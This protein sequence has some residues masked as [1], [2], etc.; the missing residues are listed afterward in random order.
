ML[1][2]N[3]GKLINLGMNAQ[4]G[5]NT[6]EA[7]SLWFCF[8]ICHLA[9]IDT[10]FGMFNVIHFIHIW[11]S[12]CKGSSIVA[13]GKW[14]YAGGIPMELAQPLFV[15]WIPNI[16]KSIGTS[17]KWIFKSVVNSNGENGKSEKIQYRKKEKTK[18]SGIT[19]SVKTTG[20]YRLASFSKEHEYFPKS[21]FKQLTHCIKSFKDSAYCKKY[22]L[23]A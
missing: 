14:R 15:K 9:N 23:N 22:Y 7:Y 13:E 21:L 11:R 8:C 18:P 3:L 1:F 16:Y 6:G 2:M 4:K 12:Y 19:L 17:W 20:L 10:I 5:S